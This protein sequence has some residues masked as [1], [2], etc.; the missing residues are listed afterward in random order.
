MPRLA[1]AIGVR[2]LAFQAWRIFRRHVKLPI[3][4]LGDSSAW[5]VIN[6]NGTHH[7]SRI[8]LPKN[9]A[10]ESGSNV[11]ENFCELIHGIF[12]CTKPLIQQKTRYLIYNISQNLVKACHIESPELKALDPRP[13]CALAVRLVC[14]TDV[15][16]VQNWDDEFE[17]DLVLFLCAVPTR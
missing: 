13:L 1:G 7:I 15:K 14:R 6:D 9:N 3:H 16:K 4:A 5:T 17:I 8:L 12:H 2:S 11:R 10:F